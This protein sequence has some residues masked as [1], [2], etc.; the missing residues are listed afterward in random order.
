MLG[1]WLCCRSR[2]GRSGGAGFAGAADSVEGPAR[3]RWLRSCGW[4][5]RL[6]PG[7][8]RRAGLA[9]EWV[10]QEQV[11]RRRADSADEPALLARE[12]AEVL[13]LAYSAQAGAVPPVALVWLEQPVALVWLEQP[14]A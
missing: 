4:L 2:F 11:C 8:R 6:G 12:L 3:L 9:W 1:S 7:L 10:F 14:V 5:I 13:R